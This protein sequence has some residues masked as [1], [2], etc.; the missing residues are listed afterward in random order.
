[1]QRDNGYAERRLP[2]QSTTDSRVTLR[3]RLVFLAMYIFR[4][5]R[6]YRTITYFVRWTFILDDGGRSYTFFSQSSYSLMPKIK[7]RVREIPSRW[8]HSNG[9]LYICDEVRQNGDSKESGIVS[10]RSPRPHHEITFMVRRV[11]RR[12]FLFSTTVN[13]I[14]FHL[15]RDGR[16]NGMTNLPGPIAVRSIKRW[17]SRRK[18]V[19][20]E[21]EAE[22]YGGGAIV[23]RQRA[24][25]ST[26]N[27]SKPNN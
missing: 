7:C 18:R 26:S 3:R 20:R 5:M 22:K 17:N 15:V 19:R 25:I 2:I 9:R 10:W 14:P 23:I 8:R 12:D 24:W 11:S 6:V 4:I 1:M 21:R 13:T 27:E 16:R